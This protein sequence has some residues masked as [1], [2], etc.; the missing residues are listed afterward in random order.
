MQVG[1]VEVCFL[2]EERKLLAVMVAVEHLV[3]L[4]LLAQMELQIQAVAVVAAHKVLLAVLG[5]LALYC[6]AL[7]EL[8]LQLLQ[9]EAQLEQ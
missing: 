6:C 3:I 4:L 5:E 1:A 2:L 8:I 7:L 9:Q